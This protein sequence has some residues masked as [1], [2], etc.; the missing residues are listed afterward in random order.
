MK[1]LAAPLGGISATI[2]ADRSVALRQAARNVL[3]I[4]VQPSAILFF[5]ANLFPPLPVQP[6]WF[7]KGDILLTDYCLLGSILLKLPAARLRRDQV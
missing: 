1:L 4:A 7:L 2:P 5:N 6:V 3:A